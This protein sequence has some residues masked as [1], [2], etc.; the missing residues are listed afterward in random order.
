MQRR[1]ERSPEWVLRSR[2]EALA[3][4]SRSL[5]GLDFCDNFNAAVS[6]VPGRC[7]TR[8]GSVGPLR[9]CALDG[10]DTPRMMLVTPVRHFMPYRLSLADALTLKRVKRRTIY[11]NTRHSAYCHPGWSAAESR[12]PVFLLRLVPGSHSFHSLVRDEN[13]FLRL[14]VEPD[15]RPLRPHRGARSAHL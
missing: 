13:F 2:G 3:E 12:D 5:L 7:P 15:S 1:F 4:G 8:Q 14:S 11:R 9:G 10:S 6:C